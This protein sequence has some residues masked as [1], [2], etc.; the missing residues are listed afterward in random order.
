MIWAVLGSPGGLGVL[1][2]GGWDSFYL[3]QSLEEVWVPQSVPA[4]L[5]QTV[6]EL[7]DASGL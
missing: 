7:G 6:Q 3:A 5:G 4:G 2:K 1:R